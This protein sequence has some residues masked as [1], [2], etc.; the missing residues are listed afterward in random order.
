M[1]NLNIIGSVT[2]IYKW[3]AT[4]TGIL[5]LL[6]VGMRLGSEAMEKYNEPGPTPWA[7]KKNKLYI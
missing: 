3:L 1:N 4:Q 5:N 7:G 2:P 6:I